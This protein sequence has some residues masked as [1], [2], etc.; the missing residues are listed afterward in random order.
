VS[1]LLQANKLTQLKESHVLV[2]YMQRLK[3]YGR[4]MW[5]LL[6]GSPCQQCGFALIIVEQKREIDI[7]FTEDD[8]LMDPKEL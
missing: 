7:Q 3:S 1:V 4:Y 8:C 6:P 2:T 5:M